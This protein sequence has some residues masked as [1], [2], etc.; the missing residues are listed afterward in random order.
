MS[1]IFVGNLSFGMRDDELREVFAQYG[2]VQSADVS[3]DGFS[4]RSNG[5]GFVEMPDAEAA[6]S[7]VESLNG[8]DVNGR[9]L[10]V[11]LV[12]PWESPVFGR[13]IRLQA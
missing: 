2:D 13:A 10:E 7:A 5:Y 9:P 6:R 3:V 4:R 12:I 8:R 1:R 11:R